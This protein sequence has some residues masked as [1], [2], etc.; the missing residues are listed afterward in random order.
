MVTVDW[1]IAG[2]IVFSVALGI[3][4]GVVRELVALAG[5]ITAIVLALR[6]AGEVGA[7]L[8]LPMNWPTLRIGLGALLIVIVV[9]L[10][11][12]MA[13]WI[14]QKLMAAAKLSAADRALGGGF[15]LLRGVLILLAVV[16]F[17]HG[18]ALAQHPW[19]QASAILPYTVMTVRFAAPLLP[20]STW[21]QPS[22]HRSV[23]PAT[24]LSPR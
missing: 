22:V 8:P 15:G 3:L 2:G 5:W 16:W 17:T 9:V 21:M 11:A 24:P 13:G 18:T 7:L 19:W 6:Y 12:A 10:V 4:R 20:E 23:A 14:L 1:L